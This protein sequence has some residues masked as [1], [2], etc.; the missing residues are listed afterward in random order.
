M[1][2]LLIDDHPLVRE[3]LA[4]VLMQLESDITVLHA[5]DAEHGLRL[6][7]EHEDLD[8][9]M[10]DLKLA[11]QS[12][13]A[14]VQTLHAEWPQLPVIVVSSSE[15]PADVRSAL[16]AGARGYVPKS[17]GNA[18]ILAAIR[19]VL[20]GEIYVPP[21]MLGAGAAG[22]S[23]SGAG[24][25]S[26]TDRQLAVLR[27]LCKGHPNKTIGRELDMQEKTV[28]GHVTAIFRTLGVVNRTQ[29]VDAARRLGL[30]L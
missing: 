15:E 14:V 21:L 22:A 29:A 18:T 26:L 12:G 17:S 3:G 11:G 16:K 4:A 27:Q 20:S 10:A 5:A 9:V 28:K 6:A 7:R 2:F 25:G 1:K 30:E 8:G 19:L 24:E 13:L 23:L